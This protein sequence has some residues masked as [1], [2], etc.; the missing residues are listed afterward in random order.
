VKTGDIIRRV[1]STPL[2][3][4]VRSV[5]GETAIVRIIRQDGQLDMRHPYGFTVLTKHFVIEEVAQ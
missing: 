3:C 2:R 4:I 5:E 1:I